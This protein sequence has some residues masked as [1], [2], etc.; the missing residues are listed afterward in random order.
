MGATGEEEW[1]RSEYGVGG[2]WRR[3][4]WVEGRRGG[5]RFQRGE[6]DKGRIFVIVVSLVYVFV[7]LLLFLNHRYGVKDIITFFLSYC[8][9]Y[10]HRYGV[11]GIIT[12]LSFCSFYKI[13]KWYG[14]KGIFFALSF[15]MIAFISYNYRIIHVLLSV[16]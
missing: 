7:L 8:S 15:C 6:E 12:F 4:C 11:K 2:R 16:Q 9:F 1:G 3:F 5:R 13:A 10:N 14:A